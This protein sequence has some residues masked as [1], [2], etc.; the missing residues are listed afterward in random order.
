MAPGDVPE[1]SNCPATCRPANESG[2]ASTT[3]T[4]LS[5][6]TFSGNA[7]NGVQV[8]GGTMVQA[9]TWGTNAPYVLFGGLTVNAGV[10]LTLSP[11]VVVKGPL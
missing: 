5:G 10:V 6:N 4:A 2:S 1:R 7:I 3:A 9:A 8:L 11:G